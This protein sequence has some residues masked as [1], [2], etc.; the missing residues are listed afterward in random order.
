MSRILWRTPYSLAG[1]RNS[2]DYGNI[3][4]YVVRRYL[5]IPVHRSS[6]LEERPAYHI[7]GSARQSTYSTESPNARG[8]GA[9]TA[10]M[11]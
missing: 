1:S 5:I 2:T 3:R 9:S 8:Y 4:G 6:G 11:Y 10:S 7:K